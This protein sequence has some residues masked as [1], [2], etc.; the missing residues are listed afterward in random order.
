MSLD[1]AVAAIQSRSGNRLKRLRSELAE[2]ADGAERLLSQL[3]RHRDPVVRDWAGW[4]AVRLL[5]RASAISLLTRLADD[6][7][8]D[9]RTEAQR[10]LVDLDKAWARRLIPRYLKALQRDDS[11]EVVDAIWRLTQFREPAALPLIK[12]LRVS[13]KELVVRNNALI[14]ALVLAGAEDELIE[15][16]RAHDHERCVLWT[17]GLAYLGTGRAIDALG[18]YAQTGPDAECREK[19]A[20]SLAK[21]DDLRPVLYQ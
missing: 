17:K 11:I 9:V 12:D 2:D 1:Q 6:A 7:D 10:F 13:G 5:P 4:A 3:A 14:A 19:A 21:V 15:G 20:R 18:A 8:V 16:L